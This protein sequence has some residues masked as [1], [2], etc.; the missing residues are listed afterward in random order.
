MLTFKTNK[1]INGTR[2]GEGNKNCNVFIE[3]EKFLQCQERGSSG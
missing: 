1:Q 2:L 3:R